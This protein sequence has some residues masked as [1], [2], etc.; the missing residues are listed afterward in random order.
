MTDTT[1]VRVTDGD[2]WIDGDH[3]TRGD[4]VDIP[5]DVYERI[6]ASFEPVNDESGS[7]SSDEEVDDAGSDTD[8]AASVEVD[9]HPEELTVDEI[10]DRVADV[11][12]REKLQ[13][14]R[15]LEVDGKNRSTALEVID[16]RL[17]ELQE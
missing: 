14:I 3:L 13:A 15:E 1:R 10:E 11:D 6:P 9:P 4:E 17:E 16:E 7:E 12:D 8:D 2:V 5:T